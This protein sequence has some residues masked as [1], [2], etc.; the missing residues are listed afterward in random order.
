MRANFAGWLVLGWCGLV[1]C[2]GAETAPPTSPEAKEPAPAAASATPVAPAAAEPVAPAPARTLQLADGVWAPFTD[3]EGKPRIAISLV[4]EALRRAGVEAKANF[5]DP[6]ELIPVLEKKQFDGSEALWRAAEREEF[7]YYSQPYLQNRLVLLA[8]RGTDVSATK[9]DT[10]KGKKIGVVAEYAYGPEVL[11]IPGVN[12]VRGPSDEEN[13]RALLRKDVDY[14]VVDELLVQQLFAAEPKKSQA[15]LAVGQKAITVRSLHFALRKDIPDAADIIARF[16]AQLASLQRDGT[17]NRVLSLV[18]ILTDT[19]GDGRDELVLAGNK[20]GT[21]AP[22]HRYQLFGAPVQGAP[23]ILIEGQIYED[24]AAVPDHFKL[25]PDPL[26]TPP[27][28]Q[29]VLVEF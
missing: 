26:S 19:D 1:A 28:M 8:R 22:S 21:G 20:A 12:L 5:V 14:I 17:Y 10:L 29:A 16:N 2:G 23:R 15:M 7:L 24:W 9:L 4:H 3:H 11:G 6:G 13:L 25:P 27:S 18:W